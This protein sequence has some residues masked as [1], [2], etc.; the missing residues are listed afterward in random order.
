MSQIDAVG[1]FDK[2]MGLKLTKAKI[3]VAYAEGC[4]N[5]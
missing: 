2:E 5:I 3:G 4:F 1:G